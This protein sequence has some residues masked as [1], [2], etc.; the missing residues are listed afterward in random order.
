MLTFYAPTM[1]KNIGTHFKQH[2]LSY[3]PDP[4]LE[5]PPHSKVLIETPPVHAAMSVMT[6]IDAALIVLHAK[7]FI[8]L[9][10][11]T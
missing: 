6:K 7:A 9:N 4:Y 11:E 10:K 8:E 2:I 1:S 5:V 3:V